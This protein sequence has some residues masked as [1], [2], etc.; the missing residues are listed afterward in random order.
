MKI[1]HV[2]STLEL[3]GMETMA[4]ALASF[5]QSQGHEVSVVAVYGK[6]ELFATAQKMG[7]K[8]ATLMKRPGKDFFTSIKKLRALFAER[9]PDVVH[10]HNLVTH[11]LS[12]A[13]CFVNGNSLLLNTRHD[14]GQHLKRSARGDWLYRLAMRRSAF[15]VA[16]CEAARKAFVERSI[17]PH[18]KS[19]TIVNGIDLSSFSRRNDISRQKLLSSLGIEGN[20]VV[21]GNVGRVNPVKDHETMLL[22]FA[23]QVSAG[24]NAVLV[25]AGDGANLNNVR[26]LISANNLENKVFL[27]GR[28]SDVAELLQSF[29]VF[30]QSS[31]TEGYSLALVEAASSALPILATDVGGNS[32]I[33]QNGLNGYLVPSKDISAYSSAIKQLAESEN[34]RHTLGA[35]ALRWSF[36]NGSISVMYERYL[37]L[38]KGERA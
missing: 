37:R 31:I 3:G 15:G 9:T 13:A 20:P 28:R 17:I 32:E 29:D 35:N 30:L 8:P 19:R 4:L 14:M 34:I 24:L 26:N 7:L 18:Q 21:F 38:Y 33:I 1:V 5:Q 22:A 12:A 10:T 6:D 2:L 36:D 25:I 16:V 11:Y 23:K 27:L